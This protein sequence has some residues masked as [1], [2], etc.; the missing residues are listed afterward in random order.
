MFDGVGMIGVLVGKNQ[1]RNGYGGEVAAGTRRIGAGM[2]EIETALNVGTG[3]IPSRVK[4]GAH[5]KQT[6]IQMHTYTRTST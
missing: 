2:R 4:T 5:A 6:H 3:V 1:T